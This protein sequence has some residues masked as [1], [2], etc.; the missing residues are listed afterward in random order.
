MAEAFV[1]SL[2]DTTEG[3]DIELVVAL[4]ADMETSARLATIPLHDRFEMV[5]DYRHE[6]RGCSQAWNDALALSGGDP[7]ILAADDLEFQP[8][9]L[10]AAL[11]RLSEFEDGWGLVGFN[12]GHWGAELSTHYMVSRKMVVDVFGGV[13]AWQHYHHSF[14]DREAN[15]RARQAGRYAWCEDAYVLHRHWIF[16]DR[17]QDTTDTRKLDLHP[18]SERI[19]AEREAAGFPNDY[20]PAIR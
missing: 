20:E 12:D 15:G 5:I 8:G 13:I 17:V 14:N 9:W 18:E 19:F 16:G 2:V 4:D 10:E 6:H 1:Q 11:M 7:V 3:H